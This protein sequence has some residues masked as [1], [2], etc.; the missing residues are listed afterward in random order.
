M[1]SCLQEPS[2]VA[3]SSE[4]SQTNLPVPAG[5]SQQPKQSHP[6]G[7]S[8][9]QTF[10]QTSVWAWSSSSQLELVPEMFTFVS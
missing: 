8:G 6:F 1:S 3:S 10:S 5:S 4:P 7:V 2:P 9:P